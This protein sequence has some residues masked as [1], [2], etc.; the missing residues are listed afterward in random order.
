MMWYNF[1]QHRLQVIDR[2]VEIT[3]SRATGVTLLRRVSQGLCDVVAT[4]PAAS[5]GS[6]DDPG[7]EVASG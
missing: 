3:R 1:V 7:W 2:P 4:A 6:L 5:S